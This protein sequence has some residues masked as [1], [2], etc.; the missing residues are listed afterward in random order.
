MAEFSDVIKDINSLP[1]GIDKAVDSK[2]KVVASNIANMARGNHRFQSRTGRL[3]RSINAKG[4]DNGIHAYLDTGVAEYAGYV[5]NGTSRM[6]P[7]PFLQQAFTANLP[8][9]DDAI[10]KACDE[11]FAKM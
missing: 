6:A 9:V 4:V 1:E 2:L 10:G 5:H 8:A 3:E 11:A 7:D